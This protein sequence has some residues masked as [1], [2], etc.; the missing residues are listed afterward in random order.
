MRQILVGIA[1]VALLMASPPAAAVSLEAAMAERA[2]GDADAPVTIVEYA[3]LTCPHC[4]SFHRDVLPKIKEAYIDRGKVRL[5]YTDFPL[6]GLALGAAMLARCVGPERYFGFL[7]VLFR[8]Q[9]T[10]A[11]SSDPRQELQRVALLG[12]ISRADFDACLADRS[13]M[14][15]IQERAAAAEAHFD[16]RST[17][18]FVINGRKVAGTPSFEEFRKVIDETLESEN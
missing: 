8:S 9:Q 5:V 12:G 11:R 10:W 13:L 14:K 18:S 6:D 17:P 2:M 3:S 16:I 15:A 4:A 1:F 7:T